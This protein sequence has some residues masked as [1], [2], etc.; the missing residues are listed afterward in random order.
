[1]AQTLLIPKRMGAAVVVLRD[2]TRAQAAATKAVHT[3]AAGVVLLLECDRV[4]IGHG[5]AA[6]D[7]L[8]AAHNLDHAGWQRC[9]WSHC[10][11]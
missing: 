8:A 5:V 4:S 7:A 2:A 3:E 6:R 9:D 1:M 11:S 10:H